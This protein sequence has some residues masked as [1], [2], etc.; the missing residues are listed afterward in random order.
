MQCNIDK[1][2]Q[3]LRTTM[4]A[5]TALIGAGLLAARF[6][7]DVAAVPTWAG[8]A[9]LVGGAFM[10]FEGVNGWCVVRAMGFKTPI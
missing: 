10:M 2:G 6:A 8:I 5:I 4:G 9:A 3:M 1:R 7:F